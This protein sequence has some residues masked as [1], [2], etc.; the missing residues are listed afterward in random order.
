MKNP[1]LKLDYPPADLLSMWHPDTLLLISMECKKK[2]KTSKSV[3]VA[4]SA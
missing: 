4:I 1:T 3:I 2:A